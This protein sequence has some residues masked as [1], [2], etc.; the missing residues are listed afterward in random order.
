M[1]GSSSKIK[2]RDANWITHGA[3]SSILLLQSAKFFF[4]RYLLIS[5]ILYEGSSLMNKK[6]NQIKL[7]AGSVKHP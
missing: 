6:M 3:S 7:L 4:L 2:N 1:T 5:P